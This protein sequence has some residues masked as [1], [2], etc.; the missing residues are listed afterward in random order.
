MNNS[1]FDEYKRSR[2]EDCKGAGRETSFQ[3]AENESSGRKF[4]RAP[5]EKLPSITSKIVLQ[6]GS[7]QGGKRKDPA[8]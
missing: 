4:A 6:D 2:A 3:N 7:S 1:C 5:G 8:L